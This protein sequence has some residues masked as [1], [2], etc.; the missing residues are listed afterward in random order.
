MKEV[1]ADYPYYEHPKISDLHQLLKLRRD[2]PKTAYFWRENGKNQKRSFH[3]VYQDTTRLAALFNQSFQSKQIAVIGENSYAWLIFSLAIIFS[4]NTCVALDKDASPE[5]IKQRLKQCKVKA[6]CYSE[7]YCPEVAALAKDSFGFA[8]LDELVAKGRKAHNDYRCDPDRPAVIIFTSGTTGAGKAV[9]LSERNLAAD[10]YGASSL[11]FPHGAAASFLPYHHAFGYNTSALKPLYYGVPTFISSSLKHLTS[12]FKIAHPAIIFAVPL[13]V[14][15]FY[16]QIWR[17]AR[18]EHREKRLK[19]A[20]RISQNARK[21]GID[22]RPKLFRSIHAEFGGKLRHIICGGAYLDPKYVKWFRE[23]GIEILNGYGITECS[24]VLSVNRNNFHRDGSIGQI[25]RDVEVHIIDG[26][27]V[28]KGDIVMLGYYDNP[29]E[30]AKVLKNGHYFTGDLG[31]IDEDGFLFIT[32][33]KKNLIILSNGENLSPE[34][35]ETTLGKDRAID[36]IQVYAQS[37]RIIAEIFPTESYLGDQEYFDD[38]IYKYNQSQP[39]NHQ[40]AFAKLR[41]RPFPRNNN[42]KIIRKQT[43]D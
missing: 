15:T 30:T 23:I 22:L 29:S 4:G 20:L 28:A 1:N 11:F 21:L 16:K 9:M 5:E 35:I 10:I 43:E 38:I 24:P 39:T 40:I 32:G 6:I 18:R 14:E 2:S 36:E 12:D 27:I 34:A 37:G 42:G 31:Y 33:R 17:Q 25:C 7:S 8:E 26:E 41:N 3:D 19:I 13:V